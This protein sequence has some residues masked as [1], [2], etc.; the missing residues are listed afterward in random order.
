MQRVIFDQRDRAPFLGL[1]QRQNGVDPIFVIAPPVHPER[2]G[3]GTAKD[4]EDD[5]AIIADLSLRD[6]LVPSE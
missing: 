5:L 6:R 2:R 3:I 1:A 4:V